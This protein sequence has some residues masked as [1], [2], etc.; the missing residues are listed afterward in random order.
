MSASPASS[1]I[2]VNLAA[3][4]VIGAS[5]FL[6]TMTY[7]EPRPTTVEA[8]VVEPEVLTVEW[9]DLN[10]EFDRS[11]PFSLSEIPQAIRALDGKRIRIRG[12]MYPPFQDTG[13]SRFIMIGETKGR[14]Y[15]WNANL[16]YVPVACYIPVTMA[17]DNTA[18]YIEQKPMLIEGVFRIHAESRDGRIVCI[19]HIDLATV[20]FVT[21]R[22]QYLCV[23][24]PGC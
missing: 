11:L 13:L 15:N 20:S 3:A 4:A 21:R 23:A 6:A 9:D 1:A 24:G 17:A 16:K 12:Y 2:A 8:I 18:S 19:Y 5:V 14:G 22:P 7:P 10:I